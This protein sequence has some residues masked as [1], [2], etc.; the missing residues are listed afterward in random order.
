MDVSEGLKWAGA[1]RKLAVE[2]RVAGGQARLS[3]LECMV[4]RRGE[5]REH[6]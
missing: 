5:E 3:G 6:K 2:W 4:L 1:W